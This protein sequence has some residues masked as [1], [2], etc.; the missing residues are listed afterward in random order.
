M[1][2]RAISAIDDV[3]SSEAAATLWTLTETCSAAADTVVA[4]AEASSE[5]AAR[6]VEIPVSPSVAWVRVWD[7]ML[8]R[9]IRSC[10]DPS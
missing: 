6:L 10:W 2:E 5:L 8:I 7:M 4:C 9:A 1:A 3:S